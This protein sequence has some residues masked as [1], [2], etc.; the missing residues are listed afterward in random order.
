MKS[1]YD[2]AVERNLS[3]AERRKATKHSNV[4]NKPYAGNGP[5]DYIGKRLDVAKTLLGI[6]KD[7]DRFNDRITA[8]VKGDK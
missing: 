6:R 1:T 8:L 4:G 5:V 3:N 7:D 2:S